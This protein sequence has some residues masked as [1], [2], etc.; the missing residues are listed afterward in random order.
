MRLRHGALDV[1][2]L[3]PE[4][5][6]H[7]AKPDAAAGRQ[8]DDVSVHDADR[9]GHVGQATRSGRSDGPSAPAACS[10]PASASRWPGRCCG[11]A[12]HPGRAAGDGPAR[13]FGTPRHHRTSAP[14][15][16]G[17]VAGPRRA[18]GRPGPPHTAL[19]NHSHRA[20][21]W[22]AA[23]AARRGI[24][25][26]R[27]LLYLA[28]MFHDTGFQAPSRTSTSPCAAQRWPA[29]SPTATGARRR[30][31]GGDDAIAMHHS[32]GVGLQ[33]APRPL[34]SAGAAVD[35]F[36]RASTRSRRGPKAR[37]RA[38]PAARLQARIRRAVARGGQAGSSRPGVVPAPL[39]RHRP[40]HRMAPFD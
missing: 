28:A 9:G 7:P 13:A 25:F 39:R 37:G 18:G 6:P 17:L 14:C 12:R 22:A 36:A 40:E 34:M 3:A 8:I 11:R 23:I 4:L 24:S 35:V 19:R 31:G 1:R 21:A 20:Y 10:P 27:E 26:D 32:P 29:S 38:V 5:P 15:V 16:P 2:I 33:A 30:P